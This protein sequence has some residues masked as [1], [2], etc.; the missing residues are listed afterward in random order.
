MFNDMNL[1]SDDKQSLNYKSF[2]SK[3]AIDPE[4]I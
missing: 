2:S 3:C 1:R 4:K